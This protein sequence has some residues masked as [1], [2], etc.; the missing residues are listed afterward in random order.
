MADQYDVVVTKD[1]KSIQDLK[2]KTIGVSAPNAADYIYMVAILEHYG[3]SRNDVTFISVGTPVNR[4]AA[5]SQGAVQAI[6]QGNTLRSESEK[7]GI[8][9]LK[10]NDSPVQFPNNMFVASDD[11]VKNHKPLLKKFVAVLHDTLDWMKANPDATVAICAKRI[12]STPEACA[13]TIKIISDKSIAS[14]YTWSSTFGINV[15][16]VKSALAVMALVEPETRNLTVDD[17]A[18]TSIAGTTP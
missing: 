4:L 1:V 18:D 17:V 11:L 16:G 2:G 10:S 6:V 3:M 5:L 9:L 13:G 15:D 12:G 14:K 7:S 8:L